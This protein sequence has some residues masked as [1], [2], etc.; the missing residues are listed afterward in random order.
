MTPVQ[1]P[2]KLHFISVH[3][4]SNFV[5]SEILPTLCSELQNLATPKISTFCSQNPNIQ[6]WQ[7]P[8]HTL[9][10]TPK[11]L[12]SPKRSKE[13]YLYYETGVHMVVALTACIWFVSVALF[14]LLKVTINKQPPQSTWKVGKLAKNRA[15]FSCYLFCSHGIPVHQCL[16][17]PS[18]NLLKCLH[19]S[20]KETYL[21]C[22]SE[23]T[24]VSQISLAMCFCPGQNVTDSIPFK[25][26]GRQAKPK[27]CLFERNI[28]K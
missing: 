23:S 15:E 9:S 24:A 8:S 14:Q 26:H 10:M 7:I 27:K 6:T 13:I 11:T 21:V 4:S 1:H 25:I 22:T 19:A 12:K 16:C 20:L 17:I 2:T 5:L 18:E 28:Q 3:P